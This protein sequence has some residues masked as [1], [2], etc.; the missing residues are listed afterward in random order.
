MLDWKDVKGCVIRNRGSFFFLSRIEQLAVGAR[1]CGHLFS[2]KHY[3]DIQYQ[4][5]CGDNSQ[6]NGVCEEDA[7]G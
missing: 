7:C 2:T 6:P 5:S 4:R 3:K 1:S